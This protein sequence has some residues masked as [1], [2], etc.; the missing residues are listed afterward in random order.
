MREAGA[1][2][3]TV[4]ASGGVDAVV[5][6]H[7]TPVLMCAPDGAPLRRDVD[8]LDLI[9]SAAWQRVELVVIPVG[10]LHEDFFTLDTGVAGQ[11]LQ[12]FVQYRQRLAIVGDLSAHLPRSSAL[13]ALVHESNRGRHAWFLADLDELD[14]RLAGDAA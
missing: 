7:G 13:R 1:P 5:N 9:G 6:R 10:R 11:I 14:R 12:K 8:A 3:P 4:P 2:D